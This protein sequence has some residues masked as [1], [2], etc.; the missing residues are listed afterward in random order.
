VVKINQIIEYKDNTFE[1]IK[2][3]DEY[4][5]KYWLARELQIILDYK[6]I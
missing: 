4:G 6:L 2:Y 3:T 5:D 1:Q